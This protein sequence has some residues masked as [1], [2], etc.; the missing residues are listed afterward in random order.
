M[1]LFDFFLYSL[2]TLNVRTVRTGE[3]EVDLAYAL[4]EMQ[5]DILGLSEVR[6]MGEAIVEKENGDLW[7]HKEETSG[8]RGVDFI[9]KNRIKHLENKKEL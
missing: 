7:C 3:S 1:L 2:A 5:F 4:E 6:R 9:I 8:Q